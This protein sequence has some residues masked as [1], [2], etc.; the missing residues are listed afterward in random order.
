MKAVFRSTYRLL[1]ACLIG[2]GVAPLVALAA[3]TADY[4]PGE[5]LI[6]Y[7]RNST[8]TSQADALV[9]VGANHLQTLVSVNNR[10]DGDPGIDHVKVK[11][12]LSV[13]IEALQRHPAVAFAGPNYILRHTAT[14]ND[15]FYTNGNLWGI[16]GDDA[17]QC[18][19]TGTTNVY[20]SDAEEA[21]F[22]GYTGSKDV[23]VGVIDESIQVAHPDLNANMWVNP[24]DPVDGVDNDGNGYIDDVNR[25][26]FFNRDSSVYDGGTGDAHGTHVA[27]TIGARGG[28]GA[29]VVGIN[30]DVTSIS[31]KFLVSTGG[32][33][34]DAVNEINYLRDLKTRHSLN[35]V[36]TNNSWGARDTARRCT[37]RLLEPPSKIS[38]L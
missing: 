12:P 10:R 15:T 18:G 9:S 24:F 14:S 16:F 27:G 6:G 17:L 2:V 30:W 29:G 33:T 32:Y 22:R 35:I 31:A 36:A 26:D 21:W 25:W 37:Q 13:A 11:L 7:K 23:Y 34:S 5:I 4:A 28:N 19:P 38:S 1:V 8:S 20:G 3:P